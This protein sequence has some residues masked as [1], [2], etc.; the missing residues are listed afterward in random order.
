[1]ADKVKIK[2]QGHETSLFHHGLI[3]LIVLHELKK[4]NREWS[5]FLFLCGFGGEKQDTDTSPKVKET[6][7]VE[8]SKSVMSR[9]K[10]FVKLKPKKQVK[11]QVRKTLVVIHETPK[12][13]KEK[14][15]EV[16]ER[17]Q[18]QSA[19]K[20]VQRILTRIQIAK[21]K[22]KSMI[23]GESPSLKGNLNDI[24]KTIDIAESPLV[25]VDVI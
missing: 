6:P 15:A 8:T 11:E 17:T 25:Q 5:S 20:P 13:T 18:E 3:K 12:S 22:G 2:S 16:K 23:S 14:I 4:I 1:M 10:R 7:S 21:E 24:L 9:A 19:T